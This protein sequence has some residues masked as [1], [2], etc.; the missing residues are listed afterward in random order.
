MGRQQ[1]LK[2][3][4]VAQKDKAAIFKAKGKSTTGVRKNPRNECPHLVRLADWEF[5][6][7]ARARFRNHELADRLK[8][9]KAITRETSDA[10]KERFTIYTQARRINAFRAAESRGEVFVGENP[11]TVL[12]AEDV[13]AEHKIR[14][15]AREK[16]DDAVARYIE[17][18][19]VDWKAFTQYV[20]RREKLIYGGVD[21]GAMD[22][23]YGVSERLDEKNIERGEPEEVELREVTMLVE[24]VM[25]RDVKQEKEIKAE[26]IVKEEK[27]DDERFVGL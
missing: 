24:E 23:G 1:K 2:S 27:T 14:I 16:G 22:I 11:F 13:L 9:E 8:R 3:K 6:L 7:A 17:G 19:S 12:R 21:V 18:R 25:A 5:S 10:V 20:E 15:A 26:G 4:T